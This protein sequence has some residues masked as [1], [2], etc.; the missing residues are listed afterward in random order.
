M[1]EKQTEVKKAPP[2][3]FEPEAYLKALLHVLRFGSNGL[4]KDSWVEVY[5]WLVGKLEGADSN[6]VHI[7]DAVPIHH[8]KDVE[9][10]WDADAY[11][12]AAEFDEQLYQKAEENPTMKGFFVVGWYHS[13]P[14]LDLFLSPTDVT[15]HLGFQ[16]PNPNS[17]AVVFDHTKIVPYKHLGF[18][19][20]RLE[21]P[22]PESDYIEV[23]FDKA[24]FTKDVVDVIYQAQ[25]VVERVQ[26]NQLVTPEISEVPSIFAHLVLP[27]ATPQIDKNP[28]IDLDALFE[29]MLKSTEA[30]IQKVLG[31]SIVGKLAV[32]MNPA[33][34]EWYSAFIPYVVSSLNKWLLV[35]A[36]KLVTTNKLV[37]GSVYTIAGALE[38]SMKSV[39][40]WTKAQLG[41]SERHVKKLVESTHA[42]LAAGLEEKL[43]SHQASLST[44]VDGLTQDFAKAEGQLAKLADAVASLAAQVEALQQKTTAS[45]DSIQG[46]VDSIGKKVDGLEAGLKAAIQERLDAALGGLDARVTEQLAGHVQQVGK[47]LVGTRD[48][49]KAD[50]KA[51][52]DSIKKEKQDLDELAASKAIKKMQEDLHKLV[53]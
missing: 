6:I 16:G 8:G 22:S 23:E 5:G 11:V 24:K 29:K 15:N 25:A 43:V 44:S 51:I 20:F 1:S 52:S 21:E 34:E 31:N 7:Y 19:A 17:I 35:T 14:G 38:K 26:G 28:P 10:H 30:L 32:E 45:T 53:K 37:L 3:V 47:D 18:K 42:K 4:A 41:D 33:L 39:N 50:L 48:A 2:V 9:V 36:E 46:I 12:R 40:E 49:I 27:G 13:H